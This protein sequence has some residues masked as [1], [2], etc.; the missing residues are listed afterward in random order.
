MI[1]DIP[2]EIGWRSRHTATRAV[3]EA[4]LRYEAGE[5][6]WQPCSGCWSQRVVLQREAGGWVRLQC[7]VCQGIGEVL[8]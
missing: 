6:T 7:P 8:R 3:A 2:R 4:R 1:V 5:P